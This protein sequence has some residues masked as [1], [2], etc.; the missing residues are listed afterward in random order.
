MNLDNC[1]LR[2]RSFGGIQRSVSTAIVLGVLLPQL[3]A[4]AQIPN[5]EAAEEQFPTLEE[6]E[7]KFFPPTT[8]DTRFT[9]LLG[10]GDE[11]QL[12][13][14]DHEEFDGRKVVLPDGTITLPLIGRIRAADRTVPQLI[15]DLETR[16]DAWL[17][18]RPTVTISLTKTR[19]LLINVAGEVQRPGPV[20]LSS[21]TLF[22]NNFNTDNFTVRSPTVN[23]A[24]VAA[25]GVTKN[26]D[27]RQVVLKRYSPTG[28][29]PTVTINL[30]DS[31]SSANAPRDLLL[32]DGDS[33]FVP[34][35]AEA[36]TLNRRLLTRSSFAPTTVRVRVIGE[37]K[38]PGELEVPPN[39][40][41][42]SAVAI[43][44]GPTDKA[45]LEEVVFVR[46]HN[47]GTVEEELVD[48]STMTDT[49]QVE[50]GD[51]ILVPKTNTYN[52]IDFATDVAN[53]LNFMVNFL[54]LF[55]NQ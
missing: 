51:V 1:R 14:F 52:V 34:S 15:N 8:G 33:I 18:R 5:L 50:E 49:Y 12:T 17:K 7:V 55:T 32:Q 2:R 43:A 6:T 39:S 10:P 4:V 41:L 45:K 27:I 23:G 26:A 9:Y 29:S 40:S 20:Q 36:D 42:S 35:L 24:I 47:D 21:E 28:N 48:L 46:L 13:V 19:P 30:W 31:L 22:G 37:V 16:L 3:P 53:P 54:R 44:G 11:I 38:Q 25:G